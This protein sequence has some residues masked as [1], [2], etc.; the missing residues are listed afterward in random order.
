MAKTSYDKKELA[1]K[2]GTV[3]K[4]SIMANPNYLSVNV[5][6]KEHRRVQWS[7]LSVGQI[8]KFY[9]FYTEYRIRADAGYGMSDAKKKY[10]CAWQYLRTGLLYD[11]YGDYAKAVEY[12]RKA[13]ETDNRIEKD[14]KLYM[15]YEE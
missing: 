5:S 12:A 8:A 9:D 6:P 2:D 15:M 4:G 14:V 3:L 7:D 13:I 11:W 1:L 10:D